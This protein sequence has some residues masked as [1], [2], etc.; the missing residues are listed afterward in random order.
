MT[1]I[2]LRKSRSLG[3]FKGFFSWGGNNAYGI[4]VFVIF[5]S[6]F[7]LFRNIISCFP[8]LLNH[9]FSLFCCQITYLGMIKSYCKA[10]LWSILS[11]LFG[12]L[13]YTQQFYSIVKCI[14]MLLFLLNFLLQVVQ[15]ERE[16]KLA[17]ILKDRLNQYVQ[18]NKDGFTSHAEAEVSRLSNAGHIL[19]IFFFLSYIA[20]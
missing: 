17:S 5:L 14:D 8:L 9:F 13:G 1:E 3:I 19:I 12:A 4:V 11:P 20:S 7:L 2:A 10:N 18:E 16:E 6:F 15:K